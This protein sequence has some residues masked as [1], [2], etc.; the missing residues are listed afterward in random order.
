MKLFDFAWFNNFHAS[1]DELKS[2][3]MR[4]DWDYKKNPIGKNPIL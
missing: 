3:A 2:L 1:I 4:E